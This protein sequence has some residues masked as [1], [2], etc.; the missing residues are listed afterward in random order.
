MGNVTIDQVS[1]ALVNEYNRL[2]RK[3][4]EDNNASTDAWYISYRQ[5]NGDFVAEYIADVDEE[6]C[7]IS[8]LS[9]FV[10]E[11]LGTIAKVYEEGGEDQGSH[12]EVVFSVTQEDGEVQYFKKEGSYA[13]YDGYYWDGDFEEVSVR[14]KVV[15][16]YA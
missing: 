11:G 7:G 9:E 8:E 16:Y 1:E 2:E 10:V 6:W 12:A 4:V 3:M 13:S 14:T 15:T 5:R